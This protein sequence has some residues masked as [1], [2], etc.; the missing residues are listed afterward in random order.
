ME[1]RKAYYDVPPGDSFTATIL[2]IRPYEDKAALILDATVFYPEGGGQPGDRGTING[3]PV[4][5]VL[6][7]NEEIFHI[8]NAADAERLNPGPAEL[9]V[10]RVRRRDFTV[11]HTAQHLLSGT[12]LRLTGAYTVSMHLGDEAA[13]ESHPCT[14]DV[15]TKELSE[16]TL[17]KVEEAVADAI[18]EDHPVIIH[19]CPPEQVED[20]PLRK[21][22]PKGEEV[23]RV[24]EIQG[25]DFSPCCGTH[26]GSTGKIGMLRILG[27]E[28]YKGMIR[29]SFIAGR[30]VLRDSRILRRNGEIVSRALKVPL[31]ET[32]LASLAL[33]ERTAALERRL[34][35]LEEEAALGRAEEWLRKAGL[36]GDPAAR[37]LGGAEAGAG[38]T[39]EGRVLVE[40][41]PG[42]DMEEVLRIAR[43]AQKFTAAVL[44]AA[45]PGDGKFAGLCS[46]KT[47]DIRPLLKEPMEKFGGKGGG[48]P[49]FFQ[50]QFSEAGSLDA[51]LK[52][53]PQT[54]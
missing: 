6:E 40:S 48:G 45:S 24:V 1:T 34:K 31:A 47:F 38:N 13:G 20:F 3:F 37:S 28:K 51:F 32:G 25:N 42:A 11:L 46:V 44:V 8:I 17:V 35:A 53:L 36:L 41:F 21:V 9:C 26:L 23:I 19:C 16:E 27:A 18:E 12:I 7:K 2:E 29:V 5:D 15:D 49:S 22:P 33:L 52:S 4:L 39:G 10:D 50:G 14:I 54:L 43:A 30:R